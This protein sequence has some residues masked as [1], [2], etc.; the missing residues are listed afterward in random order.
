MDPQRDSPVKTTP[1]PELH[2]TLVDEFQHDHAMTAPQP[3][4]VTGSLSEVSGEEDPTALQKHVAGESGTPKQESSRSN[5]APEPVSPTP[6]EAVVFD[7]LS[8]LSAAEPPTTPMKETTEE[9][10]TTP[11]KESSNPTPILQTPSRPDVAFHHVTT[12]S[13]EVASTLCQDNLGEGTPTAPKRSLSVTPPR[14]PESLSPG[15]SA[16]RRDHVFFNVFQ[17]IKDAWQHVLE[18][19]GM[20]LGSRAAFNTRFEPDIDEIRQEVMRPTATLQEIADVTELVMLRRW[21]EQCRRFIIQYR[22]DMRRDLVDEAIR[23][24]RGVK[25]KVIED[26]TQRTT[27]TATPLQAPV[28]PH[29]P[30]TSRTPLSHLHSPIPPPPSPSDRRTL[31]P[32]APGS[33]NRLSPSEVESLRPRIAGLD[34]EDRTSRYDDP[35]ATPPTRRRRLNTPEEPQTRRRPDTTPRRRLDRPRTRGFRRLAPT[36][37]P[38]YP[39]PNPFAPQVVGH[40]GRYPVTTP[41]VAT[42]PDRPAA[43]DTPD[44]N[45]SEDDV[46]GPQQ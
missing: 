22:L 14:L 37:V 7:R 18:R 33:S 40:I 1:D 42:P 10:P 25:E 27:T 13:T 24:A 26:A 23:E 2:S 43:E 6:H 41:P 8:D 30:S 5:E 44:E 4:T 35:L 3:N 39:L 19:C 34:L 45:M 21:R 20:R 16:V 46:F 9:I 29:T 31:T 15:V 38:H 17:G 32:R 12:T 28:S 11:Q 36:P